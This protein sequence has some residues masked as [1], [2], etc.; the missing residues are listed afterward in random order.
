[1]GGNNRGNLGGVVL[2][3]CQKF[4]RTKTWKRNNEGSPKFDDIWKYFIQGD[5]LNPGHYKA[6]CYYCS[7]V[8]KREKPA[9]LKAHLI[10]NCVP[11]PENIRKRWQDKLSNNNNYYY[12]TRNFK[13]PST[14]LIINQQKITHHFGSNLPLQLQK[15]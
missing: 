3:K 1:M 2:Q 14:K 12:Y 6:T 13:D 10:N 9:T 5:E 8:W 4:Q 7:K 15:K 11:C